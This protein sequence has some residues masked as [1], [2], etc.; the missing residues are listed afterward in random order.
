MQ[1]GL[2]TGLL[3]WVGVCSSLCMRALKREREREM[4]DSEYAEWTSLGGHG[5]DGTYLL[6]MGPKRLAANGPFLRSLRGEGKVDQDGSKSQRYYVPVINKEGTN[7]THF[8][9][10]NEKQL[11]RWNLNSSSSNNNKQ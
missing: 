4:D 3:E 9:R 11:C 2:L 5:V 1:N 7:E 6:E 10:Q 8:T